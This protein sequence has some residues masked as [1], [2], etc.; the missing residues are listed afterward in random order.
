[1]P[2]L[3]HLMTIHKYRYCKVSIM[4]LV[5]TLDIFPSLPDSR[6]PFFLVKTL[7]QRYCS[8]KI[9]TMITTRRFKFIQYTLLKHTLL[10]VIR[11]VVEIIMLA[12]FFGN[13]SLSF[14]KKI[15]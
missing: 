10:I 3:L 4:L 13:P 11:S 15:E 14:N 9:L 12:N 5:V 2:S 7:H 8:Q 1:M 6:Q